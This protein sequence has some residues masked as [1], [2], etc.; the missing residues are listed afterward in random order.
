ML[1][2]LSLNG[3]IT[4]KSN[5]ESQVLLIVQA[6]INQDAKYTGIHIDSLSLTAQPG[7]H[8]LGTAYF[9][10]GGLSAESPISVNAGD[11]FLMIQTDP[12]HVLFNSGKP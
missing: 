3:C 6:Q 8:Y 2:L 7:T 1:L 4:S 12:P 11:Q 5:L 10:S 9:S